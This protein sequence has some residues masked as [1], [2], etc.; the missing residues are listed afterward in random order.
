MNKVRTKQSL[1]ALGLMILVAGCGKVGPLAPKVG[2]KAPDIAYGAEEVADADA[3]MTPSV[4]SRPDKSEELLRRSER[5]VKDPFD[6][7]PGTEP[8][9]LKPD[10]IKKNSNSTPPVSAD[11]PPKN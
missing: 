10:T 8:V 7:P 11:T 4:Q 9:P 2:Q 6:I 1:A 5:R 3:L